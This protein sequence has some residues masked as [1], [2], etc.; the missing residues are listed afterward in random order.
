MYDWA[1]F[2]HFRYLLSILEQ[3]GFRAAAEKLHTAQPNLSIQAKQFQEAAS[4]QLYEK[5]K[6]GRIKPTRTGEA[7]KLIAKGL[8]DAREEAMEALVAIEHD[9][10]IVVR[11][12]CSP[13]ADPALFSELCQI[14]KD[15]LPSCSIQ[16]ERQ[17]TT[18]L[19]DEV[20]SGSID[21]AIVTRPVDNSD[22]KIEDLC[23]DRLVMCLRAD[24]PLASKNALALQDIA[25]NLKIF[26]H[27]E[28]HPGAHQRLLELLRGVGIQIGAYSRASHPLEMQS[29]VKDGYGFALVR[30]GVLLDSALTTR[31]IV[32]VD[33][34][35]DTALIYRSDRYPKTLPV[36]IRQLKRKLSKATSPVPE[37]RA[38]SP[39][40]RETND[41]IQ[42]ELLSQD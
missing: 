37:R 28:R 24:H 20:V 36:V 27:P 32:G 9:D 39:S 12:G 3:Q 17:D 25:D 11:F 7:F 5:L 29:L 34:T 10:L 35:V 6:D 2:R 42:L 4:V 38:K 18:Q 8:L 21:A 19:I 31:P 33:W 26:Y 40:M 22:L 1:E 41:P 30:E 14:H 15:L 23:H 16:P 13:L